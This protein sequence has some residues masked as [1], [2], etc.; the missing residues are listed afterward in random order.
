MFS[1]GDFA[2]LGRVSVRMLRHY[3][4]I[5]LLRP[6][7]VDEFSGYRYYRVAAL[8]R[9][10]RLVALKDLGFTLAQVASILDE[11]IDVSELHGMLRLRRAELAAA[12]AADTARLAGIEARL[13]MI[14]EEGRMSTD[15]IV[16][17]QVPAVRV[18][19]LTAV[20]ESYAAPDIGPVVGPLFDELYHR[21]EAEGLRPT[22]PG[23]AHY[24]PF[25]ERVRVHAS[26]PV[27]GA[28]PR[29]AAPG[30]LAVVDLPAV[31]AATMVHHGSMTEADAVVQKIA[32]WIEAA[33]RTGTGYA[34][35]VYLETSE[36]ES[37]WVTEFQEPLA[38]QD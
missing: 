37:T 14:E 19:E 5:G 23:I 1:I 12:V 28:E 25:G 8:A 4:A 21:I 32:R 6:D 31:E 38:D 15:E 16:V 20:A 30:A 2:R 7:H 17:R 3:D 10:N 9:L 24:E 33:G 13:S 11:R 26:C 22:G 18:A 29:S 34:R 27:A 35:E 36:D